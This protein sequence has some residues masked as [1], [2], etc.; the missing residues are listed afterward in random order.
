MLNA[1]M[2]VDMPIQLTKP[3]LLLIDIQA[4]LDHPTHWGTQRSTPT[5]ETNIPRL[6]AAFRERQYPVLHVA[7]YST[8]PQSPLHP[9]N[10][11]TGVEFKDIA[12]PANSEPIFTKNVNSAFIG[13]ELEAAIRT[14]GVKELFISGLTTDHC[15]STSTRMA[16]NLGVVGDEGKIY[17]IGDATATWSK[18]GFDAETVHAVNLAS[19][20]GE[21]AD[22]VKTDSVLERLQKA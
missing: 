11:P 14:L 19:L 7:H 4:G 10:N 3:A 12:R 5:F 8:S 21:F 18:G 9:T 6:L 15:V 1:N 13:T 16:A 20:N 17:L 2:A 22:V